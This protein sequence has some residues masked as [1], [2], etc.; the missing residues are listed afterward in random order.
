MVGTESVSG[1][2]HFP[3][4]VFV[5]LGGTV[6]LVHHVYEQFG[7]DRY[8]IA[9]GIELMHRLWNIPGGGNDDSDFTQ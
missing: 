3:R 5:N 7:G 4:G 2:D 6:H 1:I 8:F 9:T